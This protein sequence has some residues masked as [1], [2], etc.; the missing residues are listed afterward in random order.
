MTG[1]IV[2]VIIGILIIVVLFPAARMIWNVSSKIDALATSQHETTLA[3]DR[4]ERKLS[5]K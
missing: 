5:D 3:L 2:G 1:R 4:I